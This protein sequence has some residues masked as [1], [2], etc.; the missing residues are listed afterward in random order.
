[1]FQA[2][3]VSPNGHPQKDRHQRL[4]PRW[5]LVGFMK[6][7]SM[8]YNKICAD[9]MKVVLALA[10]HECMHI[11]LHLM[12]GLLASASGT[13]RLTTDFTEKVENPDFIR[14][15]EPFN[16][17]RFILTLCRGLYN[18]SPLVP[19]RVERGYDLRLPP[20]SPPNS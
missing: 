13:P 20:N 16:D 2:G 8:H 14:K 4:V 5:I 18:I 15:L 17:S 19:D 9:Y 3:L 12:V 10:L 6:H 1:M 7:L 11:L